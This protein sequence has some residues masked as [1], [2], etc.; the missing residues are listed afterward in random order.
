MLSGLLRSEMA[1]DNLYAAIAELSIKPVEAQKPRR[2]IGFNVD[3]E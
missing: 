2:P 1:I 3:R